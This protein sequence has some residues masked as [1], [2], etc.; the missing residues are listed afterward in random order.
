MTGT[1]VNLDI[2]DKLAGNNPSSDIE[3]TILICGIKQ[4]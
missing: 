4:V 3:A 2:L 1:F